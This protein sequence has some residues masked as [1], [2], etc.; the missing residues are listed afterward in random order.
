MTAD[1]TTGEVT[2]ESTFNWEAGVHPAAE[3]FPMMDPEAFNGLVRDIAV[4]GQ[5]DDIWLTDDG[6][7]L[8]GRNRLAACQALELEPRTAVYDGDDPLG[9]VISLNIRRRHL[10]PSQLATVAVESLALYEA[11]AEARML[12]GKPGEDPG[13][14]LP[15]GRAPKAT[16]RAGS[17][18]GVS[19]TLVKQAKKIKAEDPEAYAEVRNGTKTVTEAHKALTQAPSPAGPSEPDVAPP[20]DE[21]APEQDAEREM[22]ARQER[23]AD[24][25]HK[26]ADRLS[27]YEL[28]HE[29]TIRLMEARCKR[30]RG[31]Q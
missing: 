6:Q 3:M 19:G 29:K 16:E 24:D 8:D 18:M 28:V 14:D 25:A 17:D 15:Q 22:D 4:N 27:R 13:A 5:H 10:T 20:D 30:W 9:W 23:A 31:N 26:L 11:E 12:A 21:P 1:E 7:L 2:Y